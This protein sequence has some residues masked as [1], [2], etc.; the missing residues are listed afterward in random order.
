MEVTEKTFILFRPQ[1]VLGLLF[2]KKPKRKTFKRHSYFLKHMYTTAMV[3]LGWSAT[4]SCFTL[5]AILLPY[6]M[7]SI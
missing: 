2:R 4:N 5:T 6:N 1:T 3:I 7:N